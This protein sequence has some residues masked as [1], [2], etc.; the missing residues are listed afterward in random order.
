MHKVL[1]VNGLTPL[2]VA[3][4]VVFVT[5]FAWIALALVSSLCGFVSLVAGGGRRLEVAA[6]HAAAIP[7]TAL[8][9]PAYNEQPARIMAGLRAIHGS[10]VEAG[11]G[12]AVR[13]FHPERH[14]RSGCLD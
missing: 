13:Y 1:G 9:M 5:L 8:L 2:A 4:L 6:G 10:L 11:G 3:I 12:G 14:D 7:R